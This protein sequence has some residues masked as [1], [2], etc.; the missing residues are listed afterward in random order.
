MRLRGTWR[1]RWPGYA[2]Q[3]ALRVGEVPDHQAGR[4]PV[5]THHALAA[6]AFGPLQGGL[7]IGH[8][9]VEHRVSRISRA[10]ADTAGDPGS[11]TASATGELVSNSHPNSS[12]K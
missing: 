3:V 5:G 12:P 1:L 7:D 4:R 10:A 8:A 2:D 6:Q 11:D 9:D